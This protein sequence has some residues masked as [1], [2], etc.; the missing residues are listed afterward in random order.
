M[1][2][3][4]PTKHLPAFDK[5]KEIRDNLNVI[6]QSYQL[7]FLPMEIGEETPFGLHN[8]ALNSGL[9]TKPFE[10]GRD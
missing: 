2:S 6:D 3:V 7:S 8:K 5:R 10:L 9:N 1:P 4:K